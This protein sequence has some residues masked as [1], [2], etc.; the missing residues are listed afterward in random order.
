MKCLN[1]NKNE[2]Q[3]HPVMGYMPCESCVAKQKKYTVRP[4]I[5]HVPEETR[6]QRKQYADDIVQPYRAGTVSLEYVKKY[7]SERFTKEELKDARNVWIEN[8][9]YVDVHEKL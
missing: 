9:P 8:Q 6:E 4:S 2:A 7:G 1:C 3:K 5:E